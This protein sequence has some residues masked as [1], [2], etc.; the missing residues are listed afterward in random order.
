MQ[1]A[2]HGIINYEMHAR[3]NGDHRRCGLLA[4]PFV[5]FVFFVVASFLSRQCHRGSRC[6]SC[7]SHG[8]PQRAQRPQREGSATTRSLAIL[9]V[10]HA[11]GVIV[12]SRGSRR[13]RT[14]GRGTPRTPHAEGVFNVDPSQSGSS[15]AARRGAEAQR[16]A[17]DE[18]ETDVIERSERSPYTSRLRR[19]SK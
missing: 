12:N 16:K 6:S 8:S 19:E 7:T 2:D 15:L 4:S 5:P 17:R 9:S 11:A 10:G 3:T 13:S 14:P 18:V 1:S